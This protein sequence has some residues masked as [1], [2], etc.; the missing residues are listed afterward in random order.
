MTAASPTSGSAPA[1]PP[2][3][4]DR[5]VLWEDL[6]PPSAAVVVMLCGR[7][8]VVR[9]GGVLV[10]SL[11]YVLPAAVDTLPAATDRAPCERCLD[12]AYNPCLVTWVDYDD[13]GDGGGP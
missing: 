4:G 3:V 8:A 13:A 7:I 6:S 10:P 5:H 11:D 12:A 1:G 9:D 2:R